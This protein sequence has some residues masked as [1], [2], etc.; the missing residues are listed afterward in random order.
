MRKILMG[1]AALSSIA[2]VG[3]ATSPSAVAKVHKVKVHDPTIYDSIDAPLPGNNA[4]QSFEAT[5]T[6]EFGNQIA[7]AGT[8]RVLNT[9][10]VTLSSWACQQG[11]QGTANTGTINSPT[12]GSCV[13][14]PGTTFSEPVTLNLY[15]VGANNAVGSLI[16]TNTQTFNIP[17]RPTALPE[18]ASCTSSSSTD[19]T[20]WYDPVLNRCVHGLFNNIT[21]NFGH[22]TLPNSVIYGIT[23]NT[24]HYGFQPY[25]DSTAC[26]AS[27]SGCGYDGLNVGYSEQP[28]EP[29]V[30]SDPNLGTAYLDGTAAGFYCDDGA[31]GTGTFRIDGRPDT[32]NCWNGGGPNT[33]YSYAGIELGD[34]PVPADQVSPYVIPSVK[35]TAVSN[36]SPSI[37]SPASG[38]VV[39]GTPFSF[40]ITT[41]GVP[42]P[43]I[44]ARPLPKG[45]KLVRDGNGTATISGTALKTDHDRTYTV[46]VTAKNHQNSSARQR[47]LL[48]LTGGKS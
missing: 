19:G 26:Y 36:T 16:A 18:S 14:T 15:S 41:T 33:G 38:A 1:V 2:L 8:A 39:A 44:T 46:H 4:S 43:T 37:T 47:L 9:V 17:F 20:A 7:F 35:F 24:S 21:F 31:G 23:Y 12:P 30:G 29:S 48:T 5:Q 40:V 27:T 42:A 6:S 25:G 28:S 45:L 22:V 10:E 11:N 3:I 34:S 32:N 13:T